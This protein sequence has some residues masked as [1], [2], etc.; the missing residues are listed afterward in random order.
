MMLQIKTCVEFGCAHA[1]GNIGIGTESRAKFTRQRADVASRCSLGDRRHRTALHHFVGFLPRQT[2]SNQR[3]QHGFR[4]KQITGAFEVGL[5]PSSVNHQA[6][7]QAG[8]SRRHEIG[9]DR[10]VGHCHP[11]HRRMRNI[12]FVPQCYVFKTG[13][14]IRPQQPRQTTQV[15][16]QNRIFLM[17]H[18]R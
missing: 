13:L 4:E 9:Q 11:F 6:F 8:G 15:L 17:R 12:A 10:S 5:H 2:F 18:R 7:D 1:C 14:R 16:R 3:Q